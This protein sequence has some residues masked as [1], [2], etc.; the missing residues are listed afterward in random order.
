MAEFETV[1]SFFCTPSDDKIDPGIYLW[2]YRPCPPGKAADD[3]SR[4]PCYS[5]QWS[6]YWTR[7]PDGPEAYRVL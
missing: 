5:S 6:R 3:S 1:F 2:D 7:R 4:M